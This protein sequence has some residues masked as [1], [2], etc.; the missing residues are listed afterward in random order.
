MSKAPPNFRKSDIVRAFAAAKAA[1]VE[2]PRI[3][4]VLPNG[5]TIAISEAPA[6]P[7]AQSTASED[8]DIVL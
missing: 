3:E 5:S 7:A 1:G 2:R 8:T 4:V 6:D